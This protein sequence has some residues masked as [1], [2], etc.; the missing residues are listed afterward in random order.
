VIT[1]ELASRIK[2]FGACAKRCPKAGTPLSELSQSDLAWAEDNNLLMQS[3][4]NDLAL[5]LWALAAHGDGY[6]YG[7][8]Y[9]SSYGDGDGYVY[10]SGDGSS[11][12]YGS[13]DGSGSGSVYGDGDGSGDPE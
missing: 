4:R 1:K 11:Y 12:V 5:P 6:G 9:G 2:Q 13:G 8:G 7:Y 3:E 10:G